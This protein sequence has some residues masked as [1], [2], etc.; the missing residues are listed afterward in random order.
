[1][2]QLLYGNEPYYI[3]RKREKMLA[4]IENPE[5]NV[6]HSDSFTEDV[7]DYL[8]ASSF[9]GGKK[10]VIITVEELKE[11]CMSKMYLEYLKEISPVNDLLIIARKVDERGTYFKATKKAGIV[12][13]CDKLKDM[14]KVD[15][16]LLLE[17]GRLGANITANA[18]AELKKRMNYMEND[19]VNL[20]MM[21]NAL[22]NLADASKT[23]TPDLVRAI[24]P[25]CSTD[26]VFALADLIRKGDYK[27]ARK[28]TN[29]LLEA[30]NAMGTLAV[31]LREFRIAYKSTMVPLKDIGIRFATFRTLSE[32]ES[33]EGL[34]ICQ[35][36][37]DDIKAGI[38]SDESALIYV[39]E[40][41]CELLHKTVQKA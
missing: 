1:M 40:Q 34:R 29:L 39:V 15:Q 19:D 30:D 13:R 41:L 6:K 12:T 18:F 7:M 10:L 24:V 28:Q 38:L 25:D 35:Q 11:S 20:C 9:F 31:L 5:V 32:M 8:H 14:G 26:N 2:I 37:M 16:I 27:N 33:Y 22:K 21:T 3:D 23:I 4:Q 17:I 36:G